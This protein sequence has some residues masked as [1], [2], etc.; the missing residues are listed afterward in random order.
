M[1]NDFQ[2]CPSYHASVGK[3]QS[4]RNN[5]LV[6]TSYLILLELAFQPD[7]AHANPRCD[8]GGGQIDHGLE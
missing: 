4:A 3:F 1:W 5:G 8:S 6:T 7:M 2:K